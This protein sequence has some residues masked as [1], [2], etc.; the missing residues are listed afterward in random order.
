MFPTV[1]MMHVPWFKTELAQLL[2]QKQ[3]LVLVINILEMG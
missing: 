1:L 3:K 2:K